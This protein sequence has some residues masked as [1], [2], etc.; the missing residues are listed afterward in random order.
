[1]AAWITHFVVGVTGVIAVSQA[2]SFGWPKEGANLDFVVQVHA[3]ILI[4]VGIGL[5]AASIHIFW[6]HNRMAALEASINE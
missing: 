5:L 4:A 2:R 3:S 1:M 6:S